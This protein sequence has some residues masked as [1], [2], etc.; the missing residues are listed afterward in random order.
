MAAGDLITANGQIEWDESLLLGADTGYVWQELDGWE[1]LP[2]VD[3]GNVARSARH[4]AWA[5]RKLAQQRMVTLSG[6]VVPDSS[7]VQSQVRALAQATA[8]PEIDGAERP[9][10]VRELDGET[11]LA[12]GHLTSRAVPLGRQY[13][14]GPT[15]ALQWTCSDPRR[16]SLTE[17]SLT[18][19]AP[20]SGTGG[21]TYPLTYPLDYGT[22]GSPGVG[23]A[24]N[25]GN[26]HSHPT[27]VIHGQAVTPRVIDQTSGRRLE[28][29]LTLAAGDTLTIDTHNGTVK[30]NGGANRLY[31]MTALSAPVEAFV[32]PPGSS[33][34]AY[35][36]DSFG[37]GTPRIE[38]S[39]RHAHM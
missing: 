39:W 25:D 6:M 31:T 1:E 15:Y 14:V 27:I 13:V 3:S 4:G 37:S 12:F 11:F 30:L 17:Q 10:V 24:T 35:R 18:I 8:I 33:D 34:I 20:S 38:M 19:S 28:F 16:Y 2:G 26:V 9:L 32:L 29:D 22:S 7:G 21:L 36:A 5:G 23:T